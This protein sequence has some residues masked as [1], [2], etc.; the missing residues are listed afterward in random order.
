MRGS[1]VFSLDLLSQTAYPPPPK[2]GTTVMAKPIVIARDTG[3]EWV[4]K[5]IAAAEVH[6]FSL[7]GPPTINAALAQADHALG[8][9]FK[10]YTITSIELMP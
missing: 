4:V 7:Y 8:A 6:V 10:D 5:Y 2:T 3:P 9:Q 1:R